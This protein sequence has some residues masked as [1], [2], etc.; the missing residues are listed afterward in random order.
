MVNAVLVNT[1]PSRLMARSR[2][3]EGGV[4]YTSSIVALNCLIEVNPAAKA[5]SP[6]GR[7]EVSTRTRA[8]RARCARASASGPA[9]TS[10]ASSRPTWR[11]E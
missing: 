10:A 5:M 4:S 3:T 11:G 8:V 6:I 7:D 1:G 9:P 2:S